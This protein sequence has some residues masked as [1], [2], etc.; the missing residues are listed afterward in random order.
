MSQSGGGPNSSRRRGVSP[1]ASEQ[2]SV[3][4]SGKFERS[5]RESGSGS[6]RDG[7]RSGRGALGSGA[8]RGGGGAVAIG[9]LSVEVTMGHA[10]FVDDLWG[11]SDALSSAGRDESGRGGSGRGGN[12]P[13]GSGRHEMAALLALRGADAAAKSAR[14]APSRFGSHASGEDFTDDSARHDAVIGGATD[15]D[16]F[17]EVSVDFVDDSARHDPHIDVLELPLGGMKSEDASAQVQTRVPRRSSFVGFF[18]DD[19]GKALS[20][21]RLFSSSGESHGVSRSIG[22][23][24]AARGCIAT[25]DIKTVMVPAG[26]GARIAVCSDGVWDVY[27]SDKAVAAVKGS[28]TAE[29]AA[30]KLCSY[31]RQRREYGGQPMDDISAII[32]D[33]GEKDSKATRVSSGGFFSMCRGLPRVEY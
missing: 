11:I 33:I 20:K 30:K 18:R 12:G 29:A 23:R 24:G 1:S 6:G 16:V 4:G 8:K 26:R 17:A 5:A 14:R 9:M 3:H 10:D 27:D 2:G 31:A 28:S 15:D 19:K 7:S 21:E 25:P 13:G 32:I 22:D